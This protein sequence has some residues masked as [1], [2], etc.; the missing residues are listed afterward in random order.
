MRDKCTCYS[1]EITLSGHQHFKP[2]SHLSGT[3]MEL[4][5]VASVT[6]LQG[7]SSQQH[8]AEES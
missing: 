5:T 8:G 4:I 1:A 6:L 3:A 7:S 2:Q